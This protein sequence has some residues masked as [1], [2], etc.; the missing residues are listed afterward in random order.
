MR[1]LT[2]NFHVR[3]IS[4]RGSNQ[5]PAVGTM[6]DFEPPP[7]DRSPDQDCFIYDQ[8]FQ[9]LVT[10]SRST[11]SLKFGHRN[12][13]PGC[14][15]HLL[16]RGISDWRRAG[17]LLNGQCHTVRRHPAQPHGL[18]G[19][20]AGSRDLRNAGVIKRVE[21]RIEFRVCPDRQA[22][23]PLTGYLRYAGGTQ[24]QWSE[25]LTLGGNIEYIDHGDWQDS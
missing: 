19:A 22:S 21:A 5:A 24:Y 2:H 11:L 6:E 9:P 12:A 10:E 15:A 4:V 3:G 7:G 17:T 20:P 1:Q 25:R 23:L 13:G 14:F 16:A 18:D 8:L